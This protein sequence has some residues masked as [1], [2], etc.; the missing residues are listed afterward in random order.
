MRRRRFVVVSC[1]RLAWASRVG[2][3]RGPTAAL[4]WRRRLSWSEL[5]AASA[6][7]LALFRS[8]LTG[9]A[10]RG[11]AEALVRTRSQRLAAA[12]ASVQAV[13]ADALK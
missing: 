4:A 7:A 10:A 6:V 11:G 9:L 3:R 8:T 2:G 1:G 5:L 12:Q 13:P